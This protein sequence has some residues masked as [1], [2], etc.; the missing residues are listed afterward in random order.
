M[1]GLCGLR[2]LHLNEVYD[3]SLYIALIVL[4]SGSDN[5]VGQKTI[6]FV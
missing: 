6:G 2:T 1:S 4:G 3:V 5:P